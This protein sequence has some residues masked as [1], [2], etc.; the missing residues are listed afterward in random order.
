MTLYLEYWIYIQVHNLYNCQF[1]LFIRL[2]ATYYVRVY[3]FY[4][5]V[6]TNFYV[7]DLKVR[8]SLPNVFVKYM[9]NY[10]VNLG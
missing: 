2:L 6:I 7:K 4:Q 8:L 5:N 10:S 9:I 1:I 3:F